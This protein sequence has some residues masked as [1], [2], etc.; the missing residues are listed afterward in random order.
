MQNR[1]DGFRYDVFLGHSHKDWEVARRLAE[2]LRD[3]GLR[4]WF[5]GLVLRPGQDVESETEDGLEHS[6]V[7]VLLISPD[8]FGHG[9][10]K[11]E[12]MTAPFRDPSNDRRR[13][14]PLLIR[15]DGDVHESIRRYKQIDWR[16]ESD[17]NYRIL[18]EACR[19]ISAPA[20]VPDAASVAAFKTKIVGHTEPVYSVSVTKDGKTAIS[21]SYDAT[22]RLQNIRSGAWDA[23]IRGH[24]STVNVVIPLSDG[25]RVLSASDDC[26]LRL[27]DLE[28]EECLMSFRGHRFSVPAAALTPDENYALAASY[29][30]LKLW[31]L[32]TGKCVQTFEAHKDFILAVAVSPDGKYALSGSADNTLKLWRLDSGNCVATLRGHTDQVM[33]VSISPDG[34][35][36]LSGSYDTTLRLWDL[37]ARKCVATFEGHQGSV[38][39]V[40]IS[41]NGW[42]GASAST[43]GTVKLWDIRNGACLQTLYGGSG[44][45]PDAGEQFFC[46]AFSPNGLQLLAGAHSG[47][48]V[49][50]Q[51]KDVDPA[52][53]VRV[54]PEVRYTNAKVVLLGESGVGK[55]GLGYRLAEDRWVITESTHG[56]RVWPLKLP[57]AT[58]RPDIEREIWLWDLAGQP[59]YRLVHQ[60]FLDETSLVL[61]LFNP[62]APDPFAGIGDWEKSLLMAIGHDP[63]KLLVAARTDVGGAT[64]T[65]EKIDQFCRKRGYSEYFATSA[66]V[67]GDAGCAALKQELARSIPWDSIPWTST[68]R[69]F[70]TL[71]DAILR[72]RDEDLV[73][74]RFSELRQNLQLA[75]PDR[76]FKEEELRA[77]IGLLAGQGV[78]KR[79]DFGDFILL[80]P[81]QLNNYA[82]A[83]IRTAREH[84]DGIGCI[85]EREVLEGRFDFKGMARLRKPDEEILLRAMVQSFVEQSLCIREETP[86]GVQLAFPSQFNREI[87]IP[88]HP[89]VFITY[90]FSGHLA[91]IYTTLV[92]RLTYSDTFEKKDLWKNAA[93][94]STPEGKTV[95]LV[96]RQ[97]GEGIGEIKVFFDAGVPDDTRVT[98][99]KYI[100]EHLLKRAH[101]VEREREYTCPAC[102]RPVK[103]PEA[104]KLRLEAGKKH[105]FCIYCDARIPLIDLIERKFNQDR[106]LKKVQKL[107]AEAKIN[108]DNE[109][110]ELILVGQAQSIAGEAGQ[111]YRGYTNSDHGIDGEIE[112]KDDLGHASGQKIYLQLKSGDSYLYK[113]AGTGQEIFTVKKER[114]LTYWRNQ[115]YPVYLVIRSSDGG[116]RWM[117][118]TE[119]LKQRSDPKES[120]QIIFDGEPF[121]AQTLLAVREQSVEDLF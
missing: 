85:G 65:K 90:R 24:S 52:T 59:E 80:Q 12:L 97:A 110:R 9:W 84:V 60:L 93:E 117:N 81:E 42:L 89:E 105:I 91:T 73:L 54:A 101:D 57:S 88:A 40:A 49:V 46:V 103:N 32:R 69:L 14:I 3:D 112:F 61:M 67:E 118:V 56:M 20:D 76:P 15:G 35:L 104:I 21:G 7:L 8:M 99:I 108:L 16:A 48:V 100:H 39:G 2:R 79:L 26:S 87:E 113:R 82:S 62:Q 33:S 121:N 1:S 83:V 47:A 63:V 107:D 68:T 30:V 94:F 114:H 58:Q 11:F 106:F 120:K 44:A 55:S 22:I 6:R 37:R 109:S 115:A 111:I 86:Y 41:P 50:Y 27:W 23:T 13:F 10:P 38:Q 51:L 102:A 72:L 71:K 70:K 95:G 17:E 43:D 31:D 4:V 28:S 18:L 53:L 29:E 74:A 66:K 116:I 75:V 77:V 119:R 78:V 36:A 64:V 19:P 96:M 45:D 25:E 98:F 34:A 5:S 92:V